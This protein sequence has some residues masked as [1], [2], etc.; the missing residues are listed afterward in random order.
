MAR[1]N[2][3]AGKRL[4]E[5]ERAKKKREKEERRRNRSSGDSIPIAS[6][7]EMHGLTADRSEEEEERA[8]S[9]AIGG[10]PA[11]ARSVPSRLF[12]GGLDWNCT[13][14]RLRALF[15]ECGPV[16]DAVI[17]TDRDTGDSRGFG[18]V[19]M[20]D[21]KDATKAVAQLDGTEL[22]GRRLV[23]KTATERSTR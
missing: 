12:I 7:E 10:K 2:Y 14:E 19:T 13:V 20:A 5:N 21:R 18:F 23:V 15:E 22:D 6:A 4:K 9:V 8:L 11:R 16:A 1:S 17:M 3:S